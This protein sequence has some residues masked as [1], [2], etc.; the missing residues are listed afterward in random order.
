MKQERLTKPSKP[1]VLMLGLLSGLPAAGAVMGFSKAINGLSSGSFRLLIQ[2]GDRGSRSV[3]YDQT[4][5]DVGA[6]ALSVLSMLIGVGL[7]L[8]TGFV[9]RYAWVQWC[10]GELASWER[11]CALVGAL[12]FMGSAFGMCVPMW[13][14]LEGGG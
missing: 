11:P 14:G 5:T 9:A 3:D 8:L 6:I 2:S 1:Q 10:D 4:F 7:L 13:L 12:L